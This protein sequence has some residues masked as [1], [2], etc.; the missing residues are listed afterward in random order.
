MENSML[1]G[2]FRPPAPYSL[3]GY[4]DKVT[5]DMASEEALRRARR[6]YHLPIERIRSRIDTVNDAAERAALL[7][8]L[9]SRLY[10]Y[11]VAKGLTEAKAKP[12][13]SV[14][15]EYLLKNVLGLTGKG[16]EDKA[17]AEFKSLL[18]KQIREG[19]N[20]RG[21]SQ[22]K[23]VKW[24]SDLVTATTPEERYRVLL[25]GASGL[26]E[27][28]LKNNGKM[29]LNSGMRAVGVPGVTRN[30]FFKVVALRLAWLET[31]AARFAWVSPVLL[32]VD[33]LLTPEHTASDDDE[34]RLAFF[35]IYTQVCQDRRLILSTIIERSTENDWKYRIEPKAALRSAAY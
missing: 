5:A 24:V 17:V 21:K 28:W 35:G 25:S 29:I 12:D 31:L 15:T 8:V 3:E 4:F 13:A 10:A 14:L 2:Q 20:A 6:A 9:E 33:L 30:R 22:L 18:L 1:A 16:V 11:G 26:A 27:T 19:L 32:T 7:G 23:F 34:D